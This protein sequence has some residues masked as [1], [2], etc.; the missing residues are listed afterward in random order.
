[1]KTSR[2]SSDVSGKLAPALQLLLFLPCFYGGSVVAETELQLAERILL[3]ICHA[4]HLHESQI[5]GINTFDVSRQATWAYYDRRNRVINLNKRLFSSLDSWTPRERET[6]IAMVI[7]HE[8]THHLQAHVCSGD[9]YL[10]PLSSTPQDEYEEELEADFQGIFAAFLAGYRVDL[11]LPKALSY[12]LEPS[13]GERSGNYPNSQERIRQLYQFVDRVNE[14]L[15]YYQLGLALGEI[16]EWELAV[17]CLQKTYEFYSGRE[18]ANAIAVSYMY[19]GLE[20]LP[21]VNQ[22]LAYPFETDPEI[23]LHFSVRQEPVRSSEMA[24]AYFN[25][26]ESYLIAARQEDQTYLPTY[27]HLNCLAF[28]RDA[29]GDRSGAS[30]RPRKKELKTELEY[31][32]LLKNLT[33]QDNDR[34]R[35]NLIQT[36]LRTSPPEDIQRLLRSTLFA[37]DGV[38]QIFIPQRSRQWALDGVGYTFSPDSSPNR[39]LELPGGGIISQYDYQQSEVFTFE[40]KEVWVQLPS[41]HLSE[42]KPPIPILGYN[43]SFSERELKP[44]LGKPY[45]IR[46]TA[47]GHVYWYQE[48]GL[49]VWTDHNN[50]VFQWCVYGKGG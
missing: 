29:N 9:I 22:K 23:R 41:L 50:A 43:Q 6:T 1:M 35:Q 34:E 14:T 37:L 11:Y 16:Q 25:Q 5:P 2:L 27:L 28:L 13:S 10:S 17:S 39:I 36:K 4:T 38:G 15:I 32:G 18:V 20:Y 33:L 47:F 24:S 42:F 48:A 31:L 49:L 19:L 40:G 7:G 12:L 46:K 26:A 8:L 3:R 45:A 44:F 21:P 30:G